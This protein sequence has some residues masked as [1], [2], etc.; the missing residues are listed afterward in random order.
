MA[1]YHFSSQKVSGLLYLLVLLNAY[2]A[3]IPSG[4]GSAV[5]GLIILTKLKLRHNRADLL[6]GCA[7]DRAFLSD[8]HY[9]NYRGFARWQLLR[10]VVKIS[11]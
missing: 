2:D 5:F 11:Q 1:I 6:Y 9:E 8:R 10:L 3:T 4:Y 7:R